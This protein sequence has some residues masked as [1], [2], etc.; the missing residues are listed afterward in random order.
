MSKKSNP[1]VNHV[2]NFAKTHNISYGCAIS[3]PDCKSSYHKIGTSTKKVSIADNK[4][5]NDEEEDLKYYEKTYN[6]VLLSNAIS[7]AVTGRP[8]KNT[9][10]ETPNSYLV[11]YNLLKN[12]LEKKTGKTYPTL[13]SETD[14]KKQN[15]KAEKQMLKADKEKENIRLKETANRPIEPSHFAGIIRKK[16]PSG[17]IY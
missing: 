2:R 1:W 7:N 16:K 14:F 17:L 3:N 6:N 5:I 8:P 9:K 13:Q 4:K 15:K 11:K 10:F 12:Q